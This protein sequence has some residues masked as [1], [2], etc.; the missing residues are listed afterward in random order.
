M[1]G[2]GPGWTRDAASYPLAIIATGA[3]HL[4]RY[5]TVAKIMDTLVAFQDQ[6]TGGGYIERPECRDTGRQDLLC[7]AQLGLTGLATG[8]LDMAHAAFRWLERFMAEQPEMPKRLYLST[9]RAGLVTKAPAGKELGYYI[10]TG[11]PRQAFFNPGIGAAFA[12]RYHLATGNAA[13]VEIGRKL[14]DFSER[15]SDLQYDY[16]DTVHVGK[17]GWGAGN[18]LDVEP[19]DSHFADALRLGK[20]YLDSQ[21]ADGRWNPTKFLFPE[22]GDSD[23]LWKT[24]EHIM[25]ITMVEMALASRP[26]TRFGK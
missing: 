3:W 22:P 20:W 2:A 16:E 4:E 18:M 6:G 11:K 21:L 5:D 13:A 17:F 24:A 23:A 8:R 7:T 14:L 15:Q 9:T 26:R 19:A 12:G 10:E 25:L 1:N